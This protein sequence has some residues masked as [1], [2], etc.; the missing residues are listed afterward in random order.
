[1][2]QVPRRREDDPLARVGTVVVRGQRAARHGRDHLGAADH[3]PAERVSAEDGLGRDVVDEVVRRVLDHRDLL[4]HDLALRVDVVEGRAV[5]HVGHDVERGL[6]ALVRHAR[7]D[8][9]RLPRGGGVQLAAEL[10]EELRDL[11][12]RVARRALE[13][14]VLDEVRDARAALGLVPRACADPEAERDRAHVRQ[15]L[16]D[17][18]LA[19]R[20]L[21]QLV[22]GHAADRIGACVRSY[23]PTGLTSRQLRLGRGTCNK[24]L[25]RSES[26]RD[27]S[28]LCGGFAGPNLVDRGED[29]AADAH[30]RLCRRARSRSEYG[31]ESDG[32]REDDGMFTQASLDAP[33]PEAV[34]LPSNFQDT[35]VF[36]GLDQPTALQFATDG[37]V[38]VAEK[39][40]V[41][42]VFDNLS[43]TT[44]TVLGDLNVSVYN[45]WDRGL[46]GM[47]LDP[48]NSALF[49]LY[50]YDADIGGTAPKYGTPGTYSD[51]CPNGQ[52]TAAGCRVS[53]RL[54]RA[55]HRDRRARRCSSTTGASSSRATRS[56]RW[57]SE[58]T[59]CST[60]RAATARASTRSTS[61]TSEGNLCTDPANEGGAIR[62]QDLRTTPPTGDPVTLDGAILRVD[63]ATGAAAA[64]NPMIGSADLNARR[65][66]AY[67][68]RN[69]FRLTIRP[70]TNEVWVGDVGWNTWEEIN[71][72]QNPTDATVENFGWPCYEG[73]FPPAS[74]RQS[75]YDG[76]NIPICETLYA[77]RAARR[78]PPTTPTTTAPRSFRPRA[79]RAAAPRSPGWRSTTGRQLPGRRTTEPCSSRTT[80]A[81][82][83]GRCCRAGTGFRTR[84]TGGPS[85]I[86]RPPLKDVGPTDL[87]I[88]RLG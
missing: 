49:V 15:A 86:G 8:D 29:S 36:G 35:V 62:S 38:F 88:A 13:E 3:R 1:M 4:E 28:A 40:G 52:A 84:T 5:E 70:G 73:S 48:A 45:F 69:P 42:K 87:E 74:A 41:I 78:P 37:R 58:P 9:R 31:G 50:T 7:V 60:S 71:R 23:V 6:Q 18:A 51:P 27:G 65:I 76:A 22:L 82:A 47:A 64:G 30:R 72:V 66:I 33:A 54:S 46:L 81:A 57:D 24:R 16:G 83:S 20:E 34:V 53:G 2:A 68:L 75:G 39:R 44:A 77:R 67:G 61:G 79:A 56:G 19:G 10:V 17:D 85:S 25:L 12:R 21:G 80:R 43:D 11:L 32:R 55:Q 26:T 63:P 59:G 14:Q